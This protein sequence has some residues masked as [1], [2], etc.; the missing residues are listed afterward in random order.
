MKNY[1]DSS[2]FFAMKKFSYILLSIVIATFITSCSN[3]NRENV[4]TTIEGSVWHTTMRI[5]YNSDCDLSDS[6]ISVTNDVEQSL[7]P[8]LPD[9]RISLINRNESATTDSYINT[10]FAE[11]QR[12][13]RLSNGAFDPTV[14]PLVN[15]WGFG[16]TDIHGE[17]S[18]TQIDSCLSFVGIAECNITDNTITKK[19]PGTQ[20]NFSA[21]TKGYGIDC[22]AEML[23]RQGINNYM[24]EIGGEV[25]LKGLNSRGEKWHIQIDAPDSDK[26]GHEQLSVIEIT[27]CCLATSG[28]YRNYRDTKNGRIGHTISP[29]TGLPYINDVASATVI[30]P[31]TITADALATS[32]M[33]M[34]ADDGLAMI[35]SM[36]SVEAMLVIADGDGWRILTTSSFPHATPQK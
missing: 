10:V 28:N 3:S 14:A 8:F 11:S 1:I 5:T 6:I 31:S 30:A 20:F 35:E 16:Y 32:L 2:L 24:I 23:Q 34:P 15:L 25:A 9:S 19:A 12:I 36:D 21:I 26:T 4:Y 33:A 13:N 22:V 27:D 7:S 18:K 17:P 29:S